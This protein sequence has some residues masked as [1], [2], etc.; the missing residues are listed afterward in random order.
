MVGFLTTPLNATFKLCKIDTIVV[1]LLTHHHMCCMLVMPCMFTS[2][3]CHMPVRQSLI[4]AHC[5]FIIVSSSSLNTLQDKQCHTR[6]LGHHW[7]LYCATFP[8]AQCYMQFPT[9]ICF[10]I[11]PFLFMITF[12]LEVHAYMYL[13][14][15][16]V[17]HQSLYRKNIKNGPS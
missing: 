16:T 11:P 12:T 3:A 17:M 6:N 10:P 9:C 5:L 4:K 7:P 8:C 1:T 15:L 2:H 14:S 13:I